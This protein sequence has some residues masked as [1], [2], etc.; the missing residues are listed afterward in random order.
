MDTADKTGGS[1]EMAL[2]TLPPS[3]RSVPPKP[4][5]F[6]TLLHVLRLSASARAVFSLIMGLCGILIVADVINA[7]AEANR[8]VQLAAGLAAASFNAVLAENIET[9]F[10]SLS[11]ALDD[12]MRVRVTDRDGTI[13][14]SPASNASPAFFAPLPEI[15]VKRNITGPLGAVEINLPQH[16]VMMPVAGRAVILIVLAGL[17]A[18]FAARRAERIDER[19]R[20]HALH[21]AVEMASDGAM[22]WDTR[23]T[24]VTASAILKDMALVSPALL[25]RGTRYQRFLDG[26]RQTGDLSLLS[27]TRKGRRLRFV[28]PFGETW[29]IE[30]DLTEDGLLVTRFTNE[31][32]RVRLRRE[33]SQLRAR[34]GE[35]ANEVQT[36][37]V[38]GDA[39]S[40]SKTLFLGQLSHSL[41]TPLN[42]IIGFADLLR[43]QSYGP[44]GDPRYLGYAG[45][46]KQSGEALL[47][48]LSN[49]L[50]LA[51]LDSGHRVLAREPQRLCDLFDWVAGRYGE[52]A[53][54]AGIILSL[55]RNDS[56]VLI[57][58]N[59]YLK[60]LMG[61]IV[62]NSLK[63]TPAGGSLTLAAWPSSDG[64]VLEFTDTGIGI[65]PEALATLN[66]SSALDNS[67][68]GN[69]L[70]VARAIAELSGGQLQI[71]SSLGIGTTV[72]VVLPSLASKAGRKPKSSAEVA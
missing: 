14:I 54:R 72:A 48:M 67:R 64:V 6:F 42:H 50:E 56:V 43:H 25:K 22:I 40:R 63:F 24:L 68:K 49:M 31:S 15:T 30:E 9:A 61:N 28:L 47:D 27:S 57:G 60:R 33:V 37:R 35:M 65:A 51:E 23:Q 16:A 1:E 4:G 32:E 29:D 34:V 7:Q 59:L 5:R 39:A 8:R 38:R 53:R 66:T 44:L 69:G 71:N 18:T 12:A 26:L 70:T 11:D 52:Q 36:Q 58:D 13:L 2:P 3:G 41:R 20:A 46:I 19:T 10:S 55:E 17:F 62:E 21:V 45:D